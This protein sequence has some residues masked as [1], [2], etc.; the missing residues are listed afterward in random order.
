MAEFFDTG[1]LPKEE[2]TIFANMSQLHWIKIFFAEIPR[3][4]F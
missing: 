4:F 2:D 1:I 3:R